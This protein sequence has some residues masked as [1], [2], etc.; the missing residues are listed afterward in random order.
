MAAVLAALQA[1]PVETGMRAVQDE[2]SARP[3]D[4][5]GFLEQCGDVVDV[6]HIHRP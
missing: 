3:Q 5:D 4:P 2:R 1:R 6:G